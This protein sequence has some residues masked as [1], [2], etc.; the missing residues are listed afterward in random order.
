MVFASYIPWKSVL[1]ANI[2]DLR[3]GDNSPVES[4]RCQLH[5][6]TYTEGLACLW[7]VNALLCSCSWSTYLFYSILFYFFFFFF[8][9]RCFFRVGTCF[10]FFFFFFFLFL[11]EKGMIT[12]SS[13][14]TFLIPVSCSHVSGSGSGSGSRKYTGSRYRQVA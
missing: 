14:P 2:V 11:T 6:A 7:E 10:F 1:C 8:S 4:S 9:W 12:Y 5:R 13:M 3:N